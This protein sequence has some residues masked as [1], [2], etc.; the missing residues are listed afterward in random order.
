M[1]TFVLVHGTYQ[2]GW[3]WK[4]VASRL[5]AAGHL[6]YHPSLDGCAERSYALRPEITLES[7]SAEIANLLFY[8]DLTQVILVGTSSGGMVVAKAA[9]GAPER[10]ERPRQSAGN[11]GALQN[12]LSSIDPAMWGRMRDYMDATTHRWN[13]WV[14]QYSR[15]RQMQLLKDWGMPSPNWMALVRLCGIVIICTSLLGIGW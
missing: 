14:L 10:I 2:G 3:I 8:E 9:E 4:P 15:H 13:I 6:V 12:A 1:A 11:R 5:R 7:Q